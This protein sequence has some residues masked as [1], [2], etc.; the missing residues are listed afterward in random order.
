MHF[1][2]GTCY[3]LELIVHTD[4]DGQAKLGGLRATLAAWKVLTSNHL[5]CDGRHVEVIFGVSAQERTFCAMSPGV[6]LISQ[7]NILSDAPAA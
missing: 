7:Q 1:V 2:G 5:L 3:C 6:H 4:G